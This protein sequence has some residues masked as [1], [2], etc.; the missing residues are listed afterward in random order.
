MSEKPQETKKEI[1]NEPQPQ[2]E[3]KS[4]SAAPDRIQQLEAKVHALEIEKSVIKISSKWPEFK[5]EK[6]FDGMSFYEG[7]MHALTNWKPKIAE[8][9]HAYAETSPKNAP[10]KEPQVGVHMVDDDENVVEG[11]L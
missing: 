8:K 10:K 4:A 7:I 5:D 6:K 2:I 1:V 11:E 9:S 3:V